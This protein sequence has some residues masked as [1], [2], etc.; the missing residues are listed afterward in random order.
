MEK[1][2]KLQ[3][4]ITLLILLVSYLI[5][6][7]YYNKNTQTKSQIKKS[8]QLSEKKVLNEGL[9]LIEDIKYTSN[10]TQGD[11]YEIIADYGETSLENPDLM[12]L[13]N[14]TGNVIFKKKENIKL[15]SDFANFNTKTFETTFINNVKVTKGNEVITGRELYLILDVDE[16][17]IKDNP[18]ID[19]N[20]IRISYNVFYERPGYTLKADIL[21][22]DLISKNMKIFM[23][24]KIKK[25]T[26]TGELK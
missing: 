5:Y 12:F 20:L 4:F 19:Q 10:N 21:E 14:V 18:E 8:Q 16:K 3:I 23:N 11:I 26:A 22:I 9:N 1:K 13:T 25:V 2:T 15:I 24:N 7:F 6:S 17:I